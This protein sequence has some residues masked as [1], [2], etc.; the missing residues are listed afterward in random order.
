M[1]NIQYSFRIR[2]GQFLTKMGIGMRAKLII[3]F[4]TV[5]VLPLLIIT[6]LALHQIGVL[7][8]V[9]NEIAVEDA[10][11]A[12]NQNAVENIERMSTE[13][14]SEVANFLYGRD[15]DIRYLASIEPT[16]ENFRAFA[17]NQT[18]HVIDRGE[19]VLAEDGQSWEQVNP[20]AKNN[21][22]GISTNREN[23]DMDGFNYRP[24][25]V[26]PYTSVPLYD[27]ITFLDLDGVEVVKYVT[28]NSTKVNYPMSSELKDV[29]DRLNTY[30][31]AETYFDSLQEMEVGEI[32]V[33][34]VTGAYVGA[35]YIG[36]Y[37]PDNIAEAEET[38]GYDI[39]YS[40]QVQAYAG[41]ENPNGQ[42]FEGIV[43]WATP[44][45]GDNGEMIG[46]V[47][48][49][50][51]HD[52]IMEFVDH[53]T[54][55]NERYTQLPSAYE[56]NYAFIWDYQCRSIC[57]PRHHSIVGFDPETG[58]SQIPWL[59]TSIY[60]GWQESGLEKWT[61]F[62]SNYPRFFK[63]S[64]D[65][66]PAAELTQAGLV[67]L[68]GR[69]LNNAPQ[70]TGWMDLTRHGGSG[71]FYI[72]WSGI[73]KLNTAAAIPYYTG[74]YAP[75]EDNNYSR[76]GF[77]FVAIGA[78]LE[79]F[80]EPAEEM[81][82]RLDDT[83]S[84][85]QNDTII[86]LVAI[87]FSLIVLVVLAAILIASSI[88]GKINKLIVGISRFR[89]GERHFRFEEP[90]KDEF[91]ALAD[92][93]DEMADSI[94]D[95]MKNS[96]CITDMNRK[97]I[98]MNE[99][100]LDF[101][102]ATLEEIVGADYAEVSVYQAGSLNDPI[103]ALLEGREAESIYMEDSDRYLRAIA[104]Y[105][106]DK[107]GDR[108]GYIIE[109]IDMTEMIRE[110]I[111]IEEQRS[112]LDKVFA[113][114]PDL[115]WYMD[116]RGAYFTV[117]PRFAALVNRPTEEFVGKT[118]AEI[119]PGNVAEGFA[120]NDKKAIDASEP[121]YSEERLIFA[122]GH[123]EV[124]DSVRTPI[125]DP[126]G[127]FIGILGYARDVTSRVQIDEAL[128][129]TQI[130][131][132]YAVQEAN[133]ANQ[134]KGE[135][136]ARM[137]HEIRTPMNA[138]IGL[139][140]LSQKKLD[141][142]ENTDDNVSAIRRN[143]DQIEASSQHLLGLLNDILDLSKIEAG[144]IELTEETVDMDRLADTI[145]SMIRTRCE[146]KKINFITKFDTFEVPNF[147]FDSL[148]LRQVLINLLGNA[149]KFTPSGGV[150]NFEIQ[151]LERRDGKALAKF[152]VHDTGIGI[153]EENQTKVFESFE[154][155]TGDVAKTHGGTGLGLAISRR[156]VELFGSEL[157]LESTLGEGS[158]FYFSVWLTETEAKAMEKV[159]IKN[160]VDIFKGKHLLLVDDV[161]INRMIVS[162]MLEETG[163]IIDE[164]ADGEEAVAAFNASDE[165]YFDIIL[166]DIQ[167]PK[168]N[169][170][171]AS[172]AIR[173]SDRSDAATIPIVAQTAN[174]FK[175]DIDRAIASGM[176]SHISKPIEME[177]LYET[178]YRFLN[179]NE[180]S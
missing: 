174:A 136:L 129:K 4:L 70:C 82:V 80:M 93:F 61:D 31:K 62:A 146:D 55:M 140:T 30:V 46:Y 171:G 137:S 147:R 32:Y 94:V 87:T 72:L 114:S 160:V 99:A 43:R 49:A 38:R 81:S 165:G 144:K 127:A 141:E 106:L 23:N 131:L 124:L 5:Q 67:G 1:N 145:E 51:N 56:G 134:H 37:T 126:N 24:G 109:S 57:H 128:R 33:S 96:L 22:E 158:T 117:N 175:E 17:E 83:I 84:E 59:E 6:I 105:A 68:D 52:H 120:Q 10:S 76:R 107:N 36:M 142:M 148:R 118:A 179:I 178:L 123:E 153:A 71:S 97:V 167:M 12:L 3:I 27:E 159:S 111:R 169:G 135:F 48:F 161:E 116:A 19:W 14:A 150:I 45:A 88:T 104:N 50:L 162:A 91:G 173:Q 13:T 119:L 16:V 172:Q 35:N 79:D 34:D 47:T 74:Q 155:A 121:V 130:D 133:Q 177:V 139:A 122:D 115:I 95:S 110:Q 125:Y 170:Y 21:E 11:A 39:E 20:P 8:K 166:M 163:I 44:V 132:E 151:C 101:C 168:L 42:R 15:D 64:R 28:P 180:T 152:I 78:G 54:P 86:N 113:S 7:G 41:E 66:T 149:V 26:Y 2:V 29:S 90:V 154:Q 112:L 63:Q 98:Y 138:I 143:I 53:I 108:F 40:P 73:Y 156:I 89:R 77:G 103:L 157:K 164:A 65:K 92:S 75:S 58:D 60:Q 176:N 85:N 69:Y 25:E 100:A 9:L 102:K 18:R